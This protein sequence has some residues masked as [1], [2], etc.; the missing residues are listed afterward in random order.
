MNKCIFCKKETDNEYNYYMADKA[1]SVREKITAFACTK[2]LKKTR[3][4]TLSI[5]SFF[6]FL[7]II[8][9]LSEMGSGK[10]PESETVGGVISSIVLTIVLLLWTFYN[11]HHVKTDKPLSETSAAKKLIKKAKKVNPVKFYFTPTE[12]ALMP[13]KN[14]EKTK[15]P[16]LA[17]YE[18]MQND[19]NI[20]IEVITTASIG[21]LI[22][23]Y[24]STPKGEG[25]LTGSSA[26]ERVRMVGEL[27]N[28]VGGF[29]L[30][31]VVHK[32]F[33]AS[34]HVYGA[35]RNLEMVWNGIGGWQG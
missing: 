30:M 26:A 22:R 7:S 4:I 24:G 15:D 19:K 21:H 5:I 1:D 14:E 17:L 8:I 31:L 18:A 2:C 11:V 25:F 9:G 10:R 23:L 28:K 13:I 6:F 29:Q 35:A 16:L 3:V 32:Q 27:L 33:A 34:Y 12:N 20:N